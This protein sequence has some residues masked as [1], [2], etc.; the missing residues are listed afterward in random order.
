MN[1]GNNSNGSGKSR[2]MISRLFIGGITL[3]LLLYYSNKE[4]KKSKNL[5]IK[6]PTEEK[7][8]KS[9]DNEVKRNYVGDDIINELIEMINEDPTFGPEDLY[10]NREE[11]EEFDENNSSY[12]VVDYIGNDLLK[13]NEEDPYIS[14]ILKLEDTLYSR[15]RAKD[16]YERDITLKEL[17]DFLFSI[18][19][20]NEVFKKMKYKVEPLSFY[21]YSEE[22][23]PGELM[24][25]KDMRDLKSIS[26]FRY[27][28]IKVLA[29]DS[30][31]IR[32]TK[33]ILKNLHPNEGEENSKFNISPFVIN[34]E[35]GDIRQLKDNYISNDYL[36]NGER[37][38]K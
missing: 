21:F 2:K 18:K 26:G 34:Y 16:F 6:E 17:R 7:V 30:L 27:I 19:S 33:E 29:V 12:V 37:F 8:G 28:R 31:G 20:S 38:S 36:D 24:D 1:K 35:S 5:A 9:E 13:K 3:G 14:V 4:S 11:D 23:I 22:G 32:F 10:I 15:N 25:I